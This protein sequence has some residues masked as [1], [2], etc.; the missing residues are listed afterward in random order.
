[1]IEKLNEIRSKLSERVFE[2]DI[3]QNTINCAFDELVEEF[4]HN[5][6]TEPKHASYYSHCECC[7]E[8]YESGVVS[9]GLCHECNSTIRQ[10]ERKKTVKKYLQNKN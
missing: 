7:G 3:T 1:M 2:G 5:Y 10:I 4:K 6:A 9:N 8:S